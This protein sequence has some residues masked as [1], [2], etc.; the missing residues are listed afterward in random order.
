[1]ILIILLIH[2]VYKAFTN[3]MAVNELLNI[4]YR[5]STIEGIHFVIISHF[6]LRVVIKFSVY[7]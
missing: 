3:G 4:F 5:C 2:K 6:E 1:M 7:K